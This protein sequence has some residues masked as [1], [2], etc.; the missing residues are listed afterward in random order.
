LV[1]GPSG[2]GKS[3]TLASLIDLI[4]HKRNDHIVTIEDPIEYIF[5]Q[6]RCK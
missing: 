4:N 1:V 3:T 6:D 2:H 5:T